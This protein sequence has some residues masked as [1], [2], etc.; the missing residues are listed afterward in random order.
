LEPAEL[1]ELRALIDL[2]ADHHAFTATQRAR[3]SPDSAGRSGCSAGVFPGT[4]RATP[5]R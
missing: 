5:N 4:G 1:A 2:V 3:G